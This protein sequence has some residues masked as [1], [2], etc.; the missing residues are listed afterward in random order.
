MNRRIEELAMKTNEYTVD[1]SRIY[2]TTPY[3]NTTFLG[4]GNEVD[5]EQLQQSVMK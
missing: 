2:H 5:V 1:E 3:K 4:L